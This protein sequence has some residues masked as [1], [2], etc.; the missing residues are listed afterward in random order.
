MK[1][2]IP[3]FLLFLLPVL[4]LGQTQVFKSGFENEFS[5]EWEAF[6]ATIP[7]FER[8]TLSKYNGGYGFQIAFNQAN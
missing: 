1:Y 6:A 5:T 8:N 2:K 7:T 4:M 3:F